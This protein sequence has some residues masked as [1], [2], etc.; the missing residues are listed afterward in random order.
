[1]TNFIFRPHLSHIYIISNLFFHPVISVSIS[2]HQF[3]YT[4]ISFSLRK[5]PFLLALRRWGRY[6]RGK[7][8]GSP[9]AKSEEKRMFHCMFT[10]LPS[11]LCISCAGGPAMH[12]LSFYFGNFRETWTRNF[13]PRDALF[14]LFNF[15]DSCVGPAL[16]P[17]PIRQ[18]W[19]SIQRE[20]WFTKWTLS[21]M[22]WEIRGVFLVDCLQSAFSLKIRLVLISSSA[23]AN[24][25][26]TITETPSF[27]AAP[28]FAARVLCFRVQ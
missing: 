22:N 25:D 10:W 5:Y 2:H 23:T 27:P 19:G 13:N 20:F 16:Y 7:K 12:W 14:L 1:M 21:I 28:D 11:L 3:T 17:P 26:V 6:A 8:P 4:Y 9:A 18:M 15:R 24:H